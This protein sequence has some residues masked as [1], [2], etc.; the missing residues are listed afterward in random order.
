MLVPALNL[1]DTLCVNQYE[2]ETL[3]I[4]NGL[5][6]EFQHGD[7]A[8]VKAGDHVG[9][10]GQVIALFRLEPC[11]TYVMELPDGS[12]IVAIE[13]DLELIQGNTGYTLMLVKE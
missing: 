12:S 6:V 5:N 13:P 11:P 9:K 3:W 10:E 2:I 7:V 1:N 8:R 4:N